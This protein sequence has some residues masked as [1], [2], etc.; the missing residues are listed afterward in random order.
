MLLV[1]LTFALGV[2]IDCFKF[3][4]WLFET[5][6][7]YSLA[8]WLGSLKIGFLRARCQLL[9]RPKEWTPKI[10]H[11]IV[12][13]LT[14]VTPWLARSSWDG[15]ES[16]TLHMDYVGSNQNGGSRRQWAKVRMI[17]TLTSDANSVLESLPVSQHC[18]TSCCNTH[19]WVN[20]HLQLPHQLTEMLNHCWLGWCHYCSTGIVHLEHIC[21]VSLKL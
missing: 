6:K 20:V 11:R 4:H 2:E 7:A 8:L 12:F 21:V 16:M 15:I 14:S 13:A 18:Q 3:V 1:P 10:L 17:G 19:G 9:L 5:I